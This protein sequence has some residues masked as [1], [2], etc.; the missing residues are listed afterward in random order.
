MY[1]LTKTFLLFYFKLLAT[2]D[3]EY[4]KYGNCIQRLHYLH[5]QTLDI[6]VMNDLPKYKNLALLIVQWWSLACNRNNNF[7][8]FIL[9]NYFGVDL[10]IKIVQLDKQHFEQKP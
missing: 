7:H 5:F 10:H 9:V 2:V 6:G 1:L 4:R 3:F 8:P